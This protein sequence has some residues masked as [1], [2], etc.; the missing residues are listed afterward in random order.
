MARGAW[1]LAMA[2]AWLLGGSAAGSAAPH[3]HAAAAPLQRVE[4]PVWQL[5]QGLRAHGLAAVAQWP[6]VRGLQRR[7][8]QP[9]VS[10][11]HLLVE[12][13]AAKPEDTL[14]WPA[15]ATAARV[16]AV[17]AGTDSWLAWVPLASLDRL[18]Q[19]PGVQRV[20]LPWPLRALTGPVLSQGA[21]ST[22]ATARHCQ[23]ARGAGVQVAVIDEEWYGFGTALAQQELLEVQGK[24]PFQGTDQDAWHGTG[25]AEIVADMAPDAAI[26]P[27]QSATLP[28]LQVQV[29]KLAA[30]GVQVNSQSSGWTTGYSFGDGTGKACALASLAKKSGITWVAAAGNE[31]GGHQWRGSWSDPD[32]DG[33]LDYATGDESNGFF[34][35]GG[36]QVDLELDW[37]AYPG[38]AIDLDL[39][40]C[41]NQTG[42]CQELASS[43]SL[44]DGAQTPAEVIWF[45]VAKSGTYFLR[46]HAKGAVPPG[47]ALR[48]VGQG[49]G[50]LQHHQLGGTIVDPAACADVVA[51]GAAEVQSWQGNAIAKYSARG[52]TFDGRPKPELLGPTAV[53]IGVASELFEGTSAACP[54]VA[55][56]LAVLIGG[57]AATPDQALA[58]LLAQ[59]DSHGLALPDAL[60]GHGWLAL[61][62]PAV[63]CLPETTDSAAC[64]TTCGTAGATLCAAPCQ[65]VTCTPLAEPCPLP[66]QPDAA[67]DSAGDATAESED[68][69][70]AGDAVAEAKPPPVVAAAVDSGCQA[71]RHQRSL[72]LLPLA[73]AVAGLRL[74]RCGKRKA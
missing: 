14:T 63:G 54:H 67:G 62:G 55:G 27:M 47:L 10:A 37:N 29:G 69:G 45:P 59:V 53:E 24:A 15:R 16:R 57:G 22:G 38:T 66:A 6:L 56:A 9:L 23:G 20:R 40:V 33:W 1:Q 7:L 65:Q 41:A 18:S 26:W 19:W 68:S 42:A 12:L 25:C 34:A 3:S 11:D 58:L 44:Q 35:P 49:I 36:S 31:G 60:H 70:L 28:E 13:H 32:Q 46:V 52:P 8:R 74:A 17:A 30:N 48:M 39:L 51:V 21:T 5:A 4:T 71:D 2:A 73:V 72:A 61:S 50:P 64:T 43:K